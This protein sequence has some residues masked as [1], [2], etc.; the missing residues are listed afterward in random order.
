MKLKPKRLDFQTD[1]ANVL[2]DGLWSQLQY[3]TY[4]TEVGYYDS[5]FVRRV[6]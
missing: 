4:S 5:S 3:Q 2:L 1:T 6:R